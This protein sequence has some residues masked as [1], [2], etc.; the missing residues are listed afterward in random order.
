MDYTGRYKTVNSELL[1][2]TVY[3]LEYRS[4]YDP[5]SKF[6]HTECSRCGKPI[7]RIMFVVQNA[8]TDVE[9]LYLGS[10]CIKHFY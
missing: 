4:K 5:K 6:Y 8:E 3:I 9:E 1:G 2:H 7:K 10:D